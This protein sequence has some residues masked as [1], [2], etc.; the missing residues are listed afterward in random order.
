MKFKID[1]N[2]PVELAELLASAGHDALTVLSQGLGGRPDS[3]VIQVCREEDRVLVT[4]DT[5]FADI[6]T[7]PPHQSPGV[8]VLRPRWQ[9]KPH[10]LNLFRREV[11]PRLDK[12]PLAHRLWI[13]EETRLRIHDGEPD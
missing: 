12:E 13:V 8:V 4:L 10:V 2:L 5:D 9:D 3:T 1:E 7:Y 11:V 6:R